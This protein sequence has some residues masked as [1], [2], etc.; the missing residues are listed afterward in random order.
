MRGWLLNGLARRQVENAGLST[1]LAQ[2][3]DECAVAN[4]NVAR[5]EELVEARDADVER[6]FAE[7]K[8]QASEHDY[9][10]HSTELRMRDLENQV[11]S[12]QEVIERQATALEQAEAR[13]AVARAANAQLQEDAAE[14]QQRLEVCSLYTLLGG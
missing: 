14:V 2:V 5:L 1:R 10:S 6:L 9:F 12:Q 7:K 11:Q 13:E 4:E 8:T 3:Q